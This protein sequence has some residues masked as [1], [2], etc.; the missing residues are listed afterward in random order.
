MKSNSMVRHGME[1]DMAG[2]TG[3]SLMSVR[4]LEIDAKTFAFA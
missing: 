1:K 2:L 4:V 3:Q